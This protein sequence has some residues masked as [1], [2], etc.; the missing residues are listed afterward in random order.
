LSD[1]IPP[2]LFALCSIT[3]IQLGA[4]IG[5]SLFSTIGPLGTTF[6]RLGFTA[7]I[8]LLLWR[9][10]L[11]G[12]K[13]KHF[14]LIILFG[15]TVAL[16]NASFYEAIQRVPLGIAVTLEFVG[17]LGV[18]IIQSRRIKDL[19]WVILA[20]IGIILLAP[21]GGG[22][23][24]D[25]LGA[26][27][28]LLAGVLWGC[29]ILLNVQIGRSFTGSAGLAFSMVVAACAI[30]PLGIVAGGR[31]LLTPRTLFIGLVVAI[32]STAFPFALELEGL[33]R[34]PS[35]TWGILMSIE[36]AIAA[37]IGFVVLRQVIDIRSILA[38]VFI[39]SASIGVSLEGR[40]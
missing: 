14:Q 34:L 9:P 27:M 1:K 4:S 40:A 23:H 11:R 32:L 5:E 36:P 26:G 18:A 35:R 33:R 24:I 16:M 28:A 7:L 21:L 31:A 15:L 17:P 13:T 20:T 12:Y 25:L 10:S 29:Y 37:L 6:L 8:Y 2:Q 3:S 39:I 38:I 30:T 19:V 22:N